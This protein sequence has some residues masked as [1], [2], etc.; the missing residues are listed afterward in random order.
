MGIGGSGNVGFHTGPGGNRGRI[1]STMSE[2]SGKCL[3]KAGIGSSDVGFQSGRSSA[4]V[5]DM[6]SSDLEVEEWESIGAFAIT[7]GEI[8]LWER[9][10]RSRHTRE[11]EA[12]WMGKCVTECGAIN[13]NRN[14]RLWCD[15]M[16]VST[17]VFCS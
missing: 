9:K 2:M 6:S 14:K 16:E 10:Q 15:D 1:F 13:A 11:K 12:R 3:G 7:T 5:A 4:G 8:E 17:H